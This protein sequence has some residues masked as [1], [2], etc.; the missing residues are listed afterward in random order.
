M[1]ALERN[2]DVRAVGDVTGDLLRVEPAVL[3]E[4]AARRVAA[5]HRAR[6]VDAGPAGLERGLVEDGRP[7]PIVAI[8][9]PSVFEEG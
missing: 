7:A 6:E 4:P 5:A 8:A 3:D 1:D 2:A 9:I